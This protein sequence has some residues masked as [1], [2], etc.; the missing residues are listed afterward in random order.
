MLGF[1]GC[2]AVLIWAASSGPRPVQNDLAS[3]LKVVSSK[4]YFAPSSN[5]GASAVIIGSLSNA[6]DKTLTQVEIEARF[7]NKQNELIDLFVDPYVGPVTPH[8]ETPFKIS[9]SANIHLPETD[10]ATHK[11]IIK[12]AYAHE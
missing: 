9:E 2:I 3:N 6:G 10:Y 8:E 12:H 7:Y 1:F 5:S 11:L 4:H